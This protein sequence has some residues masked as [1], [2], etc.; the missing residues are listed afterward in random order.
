MITGTKYLL[1]KSQNRAALFCQLVNQVSFLLR[2]ADRFCQARLLVSRLVSEPF[3]FDWLDA[4]LNRPL[5]I[6]YL[7]S[8]L[9]SVLSYRYLSSVLKS[10]C[11]SNF[12]DLGHRW[13][14]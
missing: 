9:S 1:S 2:V 6:P 13:N 4:V 12:E 14:R 10:N 11:S 8:Y 7:H 5:A 3:Q